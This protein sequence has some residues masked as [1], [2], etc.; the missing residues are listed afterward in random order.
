MH[1]KIIISIVILLSAYY[2]PQFLLRG[3]VKEQID[4]K[5][6]RLKKAGIDIQ[7]K[8]FEFNPF[9]RQLRL[10]DIHFNINE[11]NDSSKYGSIRSVELTGFRIR[12][13]LDERKLIAREFAIYQPI[14][15]T[16]S[17]HEIE[18][19]IRSAPVERLLEEVYFRSIGLF[20]AQWIRQDSSGHIYMNMKTDRIT[21][22]N[23]SL[24]HLNTDKIHLDFSSIVLSKYSMDLPDD[25]Y[26]LNINRAIYYYRNELLT[27]DS[28]T[29]SPTLDKRS[30]ASLFS[31]QKDRI[32][33]QWK[34]IQ[35]DAFKI[36][37]SKPLKLTG[38]K[39]SLA[40]ELHSYRDKRY[41]FLKQT[42]TPLPAELLDS[43]QLKF[44][45][46]TILLT[47]S[48]AEYEELTVENRPPGLVYFNI[49][50]C[51]A[52]AV[53]NLSSRKSITVKVIARFMDSGH[54][55]LICT[56]PSHTKGMYN[57]YGKVRNIPMQNFNSILTSTA[58]LGFERGTLKSLDFSI[59]Y[60][61]SAASGQMKMNIDTLD[62]EVFKAK[63][64]HRKA[65]IKTFILKKIITDKVPDSRLISGPLHF[66]R[67]P[68]RSIFHYWW[69]SLLS[70]IRETMG[71]DKYK[72]DKKQMSK[73]LNKRR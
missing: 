4:S 8:N 55:N 24:T 43:M 53:N 73:E 13:L 52:T 40:M 64:I 26:K 33:A 45:F 56:I 21:S 2:L 18:K 10:N 67:D 31:Q 1:W 14:F 68:R 29:L 47:N 59:N 22:K 57:L 63:N 44:A 25:A 5:I 66:I 35:I 34:N 70:G 72:I 6:E 60:T 36:D 48:F 38:R 20:D 41:P 69:R 39:L 49:D 11:G 46:D 23:V 54:L 51:I 12:K 61:D 17:Q 50:T 65:I 32:S 27:C 19:E 58:L 42:R 9:L 62:I 15:Y 37:V 30:F 7:Y 3:F 16:R 28:I 71:I